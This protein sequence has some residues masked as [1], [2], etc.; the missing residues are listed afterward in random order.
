MFYQVWIRVI[1]DIWWEV[2]IFWL[3]WYNKLLAL[4]F[5]VDSRLHPLEV[6]PT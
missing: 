4:W 1:G 3:G 5:C 6:K 2:D